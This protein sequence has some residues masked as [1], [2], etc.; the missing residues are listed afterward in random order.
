MPAEL[1]RI[2]EPA[3][4]A[5]PA[6]SFAATFELGF[7]PLYALGMAWAGLVV[8]AWVFAPGVARAPLAGL[9]W[10]AHEMLWGFVATIA[11]GFLLTAVPNWTGRPTLRGW[12]LAA[13]CLV[14][15]LARVGLL[16]GGQWFKP[17][18]VLDVVFF[19]AAALACAWPIAKAHNWR[20]L[21]VPLLLL[22]LGATDAA[23]LWSAQDAALPALWRAMQS[24]LLVMAVVAALIARRVI[25]FFA[26]RA[27]SGLQVELG[28]RSGVVSLGLLVL[29]VGLQMSG[30]WPWIEGLALLAS[31]GIMLS[32]LWHWKP[33][34][35]WR[36]PLLWILYLGYAGLTAGL[37]ARGA[38]AL[39]A[40]VPDSLWIHLLAVCGFAL[41][42][43]GMVTRTS[44]G[45]L[46]RALRLDRWSLSSYGF[47]LGAAA[48]RLL[49]FLPWTPTA[50][51]AL[52]ASAVSWALGCGVFVLRYLPWLVRPR[53]DKP[54][55][56]TGI[57]RKSG[58][59]RG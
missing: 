17:A 36:Q 18:A 5:L 19:V 15:L 7:R 47:L 50:E 12:P 30:R 9:F 37:A 14:W 16:A 49:A 3:R 26:M 54:L 57:V 39:G 1:L 55:A 2:E 41:L 13:L 53:I 59:V 28:A 52:R 23:F 42:I 46:G 48:L 25:P 11:V 31:A 6:P 34:R 4:A 35:V 45:H 10:H 24:G 8:L 20:N 51:F 44:L 58:V 33:W 27:V 38:Q 40:P 21:A 32:H 29:A 56:V 22:G 43:I